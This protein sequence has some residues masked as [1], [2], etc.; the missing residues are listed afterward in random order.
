MQLVKIFYAQ[1]VEIWLK[2][3]PNIVVTHYHITGRISKAYF[4]SATAAVAA[5]VLRK[6]GKRH[7]FNELEPGRI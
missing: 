7:I 6:T 4:K 2:N 1:G 3:C 5:N